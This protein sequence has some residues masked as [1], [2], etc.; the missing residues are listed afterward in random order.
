MREK[1]ERVRVLREGREKR[2]SEAFDPNGIGLYGQLCKRIC[3]LNCMSAEPK[4]GKNHLILS[5][6]PSNY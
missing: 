3:S 2:G 4:K 1:G 6:N 5:A